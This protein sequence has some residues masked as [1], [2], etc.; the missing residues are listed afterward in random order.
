MQRLF[1]QQRGF[2]LIEALLQLFIVLLIVQLLLSYQLVMKTFQQ[3]FYSDDVYWEMFVYDMQRYI[4]Q[5]SE[6]FTVYNASYFERRRPDVPTDNGIA[7]ERFDVMVDGAYIRRTLRSG[8]EPLLY[9]V[10][11]MHVEI[12]DNVLTLQVTFLDGR[13][14]ER[15]FY[16]Q[17]AT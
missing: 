13:I 15:D 3:T 2:T 7:T 14:K 11:R 9:N 4:D 10:R 5:S 17:T 12:E 16:V 1:K 6:P 8:N